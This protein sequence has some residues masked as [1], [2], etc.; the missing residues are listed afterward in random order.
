MWTLSAPFVFCNINSSISRRNTVTS[1]Q[2]L[3][4]T[5]FNLKDDTTME[6]T[7]RRSA[8]YAPSLWSYDFIQSL[9]SKYTGEKYESRSRTLKAVVTRMIC[10]EN[11][12]MENPLS[13]LNLIDDL[14]RLGISYHF[15][16]EISKAL[17][18]VY[19]NYYKNHE[20]WS[21]M[22][23]NLKSLGF[24]LLR[25]HGYHIP[26]EIFNDNIDENGVVKGHLH[27]GIVSMLNLYEACYH[28]VE[29]ES[30][31]D[32]ARIFTEKYLKQAIQNDIDDK[33]NASLINRALVF[34][35]HWMPPRVEAKWFIDVYEKRNGI[36]NNPMVLELAKLDF[37][38]VQAV[39]QEDLKN[40]SRWWKDSRWDEFDFARDRLL[41]NFMW[42][43]AENY[44]PH[45]KGRIDLTKVNAM[46]T[47]IDDVYD[48]YGTLQE[49]EQFT[50]NVNSW[51]VDKIKELPNY[52]KICFFALNNAINEMSYDVLANDG[53]FVL[54]YL[55][56]AWQDLC[57]A[58][59]IEARWFNSGYTPTLKEF[60]DNAYMSIGILPIIK[61]AYILSLASVSEDTLK[62]IER[63]ENMIRY[64]CLIVRLTNDMGTSSDELE[65][66]DVPKSIQCHMHESGATEVEAREH[67]K[68]VIM[69]TWKKLNKERLA[70]GSEFPREF[71]ECV[72]NLPRMGH[73]MYTDGDKHGKPDM[74][75][76]Y[77][78]S[79]F[80]HPI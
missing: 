38:M 2:K 47:T 22:D 33:Y 5:R 68:K 12:M 56:K 76:P 54:P 29:D 44:L 40:A 39:H 36:N 7:T 17:E 21:K 18:K 55:K 15:V 73:F 43:I 26:Q 1:K 65:R 77:A 48:V 42:T 27:E 80:V 4:S 53:V 46:I 67:I 25:Q 16:S 78:L 79:L 23:L 63:A 61:H 62:Q 6:I 11:E 32:N 10:K 50:D 66:G 70:V 3:H 41:E 13:I 31:L 75:K 14:Q 35:L 51:D 45:F 64:S 52:M 34:P 20:E 71:I 72:T 69:E 28:S 30:I 74:F 59:I 57:N 19:F 9:S 60:F 49:L 24:R 58:Y 37:N 8:N